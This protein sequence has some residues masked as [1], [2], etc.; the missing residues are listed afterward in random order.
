MVFIAMRY[1]HI[2][3]NIVALSGIAIAI[4][5]M[6]DLGHHPFGELIRHM[7]EDKGRSPLF[8]VVQNACIEVGPA[9]LTAV[10]TTIV[11]F[12]PVFT[13][14]AAEGKLFRPLA[15]TK[16]FALLGAVIVALFILPTFIHLVFGTNARKRWTRI[17][18]YAVMGIGGVTALLFGHGWAGITLL[19]L[20][21]AHGVQ[22]RVKSNHSL[23]A[24]WS[25][26][27]C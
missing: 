4:G 13:M 24:T 14:E 7:D 27:W 12:I 23:S 21:V 26:A 15:F 25:S 11:S 9:I 16:S 8:D 5:T 20:F 2:D 18:L 17:A 6:V 3:A 19:A 10:S 22:E 1:F